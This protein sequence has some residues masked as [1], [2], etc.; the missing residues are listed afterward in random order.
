[1]IESRRGRRAKH[2]G[3][4]KKERNAYS[5]FYSTYIYIYIY[6]HVKKITTWKNKTY[7]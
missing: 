3:H 2:V 7:M 1:M 6:V 5:A 4:I